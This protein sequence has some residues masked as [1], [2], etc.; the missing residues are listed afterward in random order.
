MAALRSLCV[1]CGSSEGLRPSYRRAAE[2][3][4]A[5]LAKRNVALV[6]GGG[7]VGLMGAIADAVLAARG[8]A[9]GVIPRALM[10]REV[11]HLGLTKLHVVETMHERKALMANLS[12]AFVALPGGFGTFEEFCEVLTWSQLGL[13]GKPCGLLN[14]DGYYDALL[15]LFDHA[16]EEK[17]VQ[18]LNRSMVVADTDPARLLDRLENYD[19]PLVPRWIAR[20]HT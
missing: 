19:A 4:G 3:F 17:F 5:L 20:E 15:A 13:H 8:Q 1:F 10:D 6:F 11:G 9:I 14:V 7:R 18:P 12:D 2:H 16:V